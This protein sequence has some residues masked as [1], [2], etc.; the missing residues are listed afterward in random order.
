VVL[1]AGTRNDRLRLCVASPLHEQT[2]A[3][4]AVLAEVCRKE[5]SVPERIANMEKR[6]RS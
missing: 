3:S 4:V 6:A 2:R 1:S 5:F